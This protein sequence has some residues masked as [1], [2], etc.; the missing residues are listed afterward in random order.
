MDAS[1]LARALDNFEKSWSSL[2]WWLDFWTILVVVGVAVELAVLITEYIH[3]WRDFRR[4]TIHS[5]DRPKLV[6]FSLGFIGAGL[7]A[8]GV[9]GEF[10]VHIKAGKIETGI[11]DTTRQLVAIAETEAGD[12]RREGMPDRS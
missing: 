2:D 7:V 10:R 12:A 3:D 1:A 5:P 11:R 9:A 8:I 6:V 4:A